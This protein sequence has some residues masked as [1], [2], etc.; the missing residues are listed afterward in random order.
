MLLRS[1]GIVE[2]ALFILRI[3]LKLEVKRKSWGKKKAALS[4]CLYTWNTC[5]FPLDNLQLVLCPAFKW[6]LESSSFR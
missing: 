3:L 2:G 6:A 5:D 4:S 1:Y